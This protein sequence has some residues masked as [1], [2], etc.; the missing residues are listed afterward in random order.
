MLGR[1]F[2]NEL[3]AKIAAYDPHVILVPSIWPE[4]Y[5]YVLSSA[6]ASGRR[7]A[8]FDIGAQAERTHAH[9]QEHLLFPLELAYR[10]GELLDALLAAARA[11]DQDVQRAAA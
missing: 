5:C 4:T 1:Y 6:L 3:Q 9:D 7:V 2:D 10:P 11:A 8:V